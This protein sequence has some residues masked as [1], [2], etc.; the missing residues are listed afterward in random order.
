[1]KYAD[2]LVNSNR[3]ALQFEVKDRRILDQLWSQ[4]NQSHCC[5]S[6]LLASQSIV[7]RSDADTAD[8]QMFLIDFM[9]SFLVD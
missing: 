3:R 1:M 6:R 9:L 2:L 5:L 4:D 7:S 8:I